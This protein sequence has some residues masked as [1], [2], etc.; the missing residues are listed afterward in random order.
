MSN[1]TSA[2]QPRALWRRFGKNFAAHGYS[3]VVTLV[4]QFLTVPFFLHYWGTERYAEWLVL[5]GVPIM[6]GLL[7]FGVAHASTSKATMLAAK[8][9]T[10]GVRRSL[11]TAV[12]FSLAVVAVISVL[13]AMINRLT[14]WSSLLKLTTLDTAHARQVL[15]LL[16]AHL[17]INLLGGPLNAWFVA[18]DRTATGYFL[19]ANRRLLDVLV[20]IAILAGGGN[21]VTLAM[22][23]AGG[24]ALLLLGL[25][26]LARR[27]SPWPI[28]GL[29]H[30]SVHEFRSILKPAIGHVGITFGQVITLQGGLQLLNQIAPASVVVLYS[31]ARTLMRLV[32]Q[33]STVANR[34]LRPELSRLLGAGNRQMAKHF[35]RNIGIGAA[36]SALGVYLGLLVIGPW[37]MAWWSR[38]AVIASRPELAVIGLHALLNIPWTIAAAYLMAGN[39]HSRLSLVYF[40]GCV[41]GI[42]YWILLIQFSG[43]RAHPL[44][45]ASTALSIPE[46][47][48]TLYFA[49]IYTQH[50]VNIKK[51]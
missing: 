47:F 37:I 10:E 32:I 39:A 14:N 22:A 44:F 21:A 49:H 45:L 34:A 38:G 20:T 24:Q 11:Q 8:H 29:R 50:S 43:A 16:S 13:V 1:N 19:L 2:A 26:L 30:A 48:A 3:Q 40:S 7:D 36:A 31:M 15:L 6:L 5:S 46:A 35:T 23:L 41:T 12:A 17:G 25:T 51:R 4:V 18:M 28:L 33:I 42:A 9:D 27:I